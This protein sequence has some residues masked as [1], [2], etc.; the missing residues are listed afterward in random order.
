MDHLHI[1]VHLKLMI[2]YLHFQVHGVIERQC[3]KDYS[4][5]QGLDMV[6]QV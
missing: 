1:L 5:N 4:Y 6:Q 3:H 2:E